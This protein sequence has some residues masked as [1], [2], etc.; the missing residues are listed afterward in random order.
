MTRLALLGLLVAAFSLPLL[1]TSEASAQSTMDK[2]TLD[3][4]K[5]ATV[6]IKIKAGKM[7]GSGSGFVFKNLGGRVLVMTNRHVAVPDEDDLPPDGKFDLSAVFRSGTAEEQELPAKLIAY[8]SEDAVD[9]AV[10]EVQ[11]LRNIPEPLQA[12][13]TTAEGEFYE[14]M[15]VY[16]M[17]FPRGAMMS[18]IG[19]NAKGNPAVTVNAMS[20]SSFR[21]NNANKLSRVQLNG[22]LIEGNSGGPVVDPKGRLV[23]VVVERLIGEAVGF[24][25]PPTIIAY[26][27]SG[28][29]GAPILVEVL[30]SVGPG[31]QLKIVWRLSDPLARISGVGLRYTTKP[32]SPQALQ[33]IP[34]GAGAFPEIPGSVVK[35]MKEADRVTATFPVPINT[36]EDRKLYIQFVKYDFTGKPDAIGRPI[37]IPIPDRP[38]RILD[39]ESSESGGAE[40]PTPR[41]SCLSNLGE[42]IKITSKPDSTSITL[43]PGIPLN[44][45]PQY[46][47]F[48][49]PC[50]LVKVSG[51]F[52][53]AVMVDRSLDP[54]TEAVTLPN[55]KKLSF[56]FQ[57]A[58]LLIWQ[59]DKNFVRFE[60]AK[61]SDG[62]LMGTKNQ[63][64]VEVYKRG[65]SELTF[66]KDIPDLPMAL[67]AIRQG[68]GLHLFFELPNNQRALFR[69]MQIDFK[70]DIFV[71]IA[72]ANLSNRALTAKFQEF[73][74]IDLQKN[75]IEPKPLKMD[76]LVPP[77]YVKLPN[78]TL[79]IEGANMRST[80]KG[81]DS[82]SAQN[83]ADFKGSW[84]DNRQ[85]L[86]NNSKSDGL[87]QLEFPVEAD[88]K[89]EVKGKFTMGPEYGIAML[90]ID[91]QKLSRGGK[92]DFYSQEVKP[93]ALMSMGTFQL[94]AGKHKLSVQIFKKS[95]KSTATTG[96]HFGIDEFQL[97]PVK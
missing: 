10:I 34:G 87:L 23:G 62:G 66:Y 81:A 54:G 92:I 93:T 88:G 44:N 89:F 73:V 57:S 51:D 60:R 71:G 59:D 32:L 30:G 8:S 90:D 95:A 47:L 61:K 72:A 86:W 84:S 43:P 2:A 45:A 3:R 65:K 53:S 22:A 35:M 91:G 82:V 64:L 68:S 83:M 27:L 56:S 94:K 69:E 31:T 14:T 11:G 63:L 85:L 55:G 33:P 70:D 28:H 24:A 48:N 29:L 49:A 26:F 13:L 38:G 18:A 9:L 52:I 50:A 16:S 80:G 67:V 5:A 17:G 37:L 97:V 12:D 76:R 46:D 41:W 79:I 96:Y 74:L 25:I 77:A 21:R 75:P 4:V 15:P 20:I 42:G 1:V 58:G 78:G 7:Q 39:V 6:F 40:K 19:G 36:Q